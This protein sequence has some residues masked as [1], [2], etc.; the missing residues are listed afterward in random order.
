MPTSITWLE[1]GTLAIASLKGD[2]YL[3]R[4]TNGDGIEDKL[5]LFEEGLSAP[6][7]ILSDN[8]QVDPDRKS[9]V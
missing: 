1:N 3:A 6:Y 9:V 8:R 7:G 2:I 5:I 4:D